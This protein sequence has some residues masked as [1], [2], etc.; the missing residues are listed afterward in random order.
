MV[1]NVNDSFTSTDLDRDGNAITYSITGGNALGGFAI[2]PATGQITVNNSAV[3][4]YE[5]TPSFTLTVQASDGTLTGTATIT[6]NLTNVVEG[7]PPAQTPQTISTIPPSLLPIPSSGPHP[8]SSVSAPIPAG[9]PIVLPTTNGSGS[10]LPPPA[11]VWAPGACDN[12]GDSEVNPATIMAQMWM[13][14]ACES[15]ETLTAESGVPDDPDRQADLTG[16]T[17]SMA[18]ESPEV[19]EDVRRAQV[20]E[21]LS[22]PVKKMLESGRKMAANLDRLADDLTRSMQER[23]QQAQLM[24]RM[25]SF[26]GLT[27]TAGFS[28]WVLRGG[29]VMLSFLVSMPVWRY[30]DPMPVLGMNRRDRQKFDQQARAAQQQENSQFGGLGR[31]VQSKTNPMRGHTQGTGRKKDKES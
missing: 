21:P 5:T 31:V 30:F 3:L 18:E 8:V 19:L 20:M 14:G 16:Q 29:S 12:N 27:L 15:D 13:P 9:P 25:A 11:A 6:I 1:Y 26:A 7:V 22:S 24:G 2:N 28:A 23:E 10:V 4:D 17:I